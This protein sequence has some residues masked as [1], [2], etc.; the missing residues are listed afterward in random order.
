MNAKHMIATV[1]MIA[2][3][4]SAFAQQGEWVDPAANFVPTKTRADVIAAM[5]QAQAEGAYV[6]GGAETQELYSQL[7]PNNRS[8]SGRAVAQGKT[9]A[10]VY[11]ELAHAQ[12]DATYMAGG[13][14]FPGQAQFA[15]R[16]VR[17]RG[18]AA[19]VARNGN[20][21]SGVSGS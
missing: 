1:A 18:A 19:D 6:A 8:A 10:D 14:E 7:A 12:A 13:E 16:T 3:T 15:T 17:V 11:N 9:R 21:K 20:S 4:G 2:A 5:K